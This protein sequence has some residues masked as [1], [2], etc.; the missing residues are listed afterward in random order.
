[1]PIKRPMIDSMQR[2]IFDD[3]FTPKEAV[4]PLLKNIDKEFAGGT[5][6]ECT[7]FGDSKISEAFDEAGYNVVGTDIIHGFDFLK[8]EPDFDFDFIVTNPP[9]SLKT[10]FLKR[11]YEIGKPFALLLPLTALE[12]IERGKLY[13]EYGLSL[14]VHNRRI[15]FINQ[16]KANW[17]NASWFVWQLMY[18]RDYIKFENVERT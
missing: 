10:Q 14:I 1:M 11:C 2:E 18:L 8:D 3:I 4:Y 12:G 13:S 9:Y 6:W 7:D 16:K 17:F 5:V 15:N